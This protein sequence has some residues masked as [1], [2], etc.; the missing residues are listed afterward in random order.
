MVTHTGGLPGYVSRVAMIP[1]LKLGVAVFTNQESGYAF[2]AI[3]N[4]ILDAFLGADDTDWLA[5]YAQAA[6]ASAQRTAAIEAASAGSRNALSTPSLALPDY[7][8]TYRDAWYGD[9]KVLSSE[10]GLRMEF[11]HT[12]SLVGTLEHWQ[13]DTFVVRWDNRELRAD[14][15]VTFSL[16][17]DGKIE[18]VK[19]AAASPLVDFSYDFEDLVLIPVR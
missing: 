5:A 1:E 12:P 18:V 17:P 3:V 11:T 14:A 16:G 7:V 13:Y 4:H 9:V 15:F 10:G 2:N 8:G 6:T 19:M